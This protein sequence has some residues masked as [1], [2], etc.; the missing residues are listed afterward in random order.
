MYK[1]TT[2]PISITHSD[3]M[4]KVTG[5]TLV[6]GQ[7]YM[8]TDYIAYTSQ[9]GTT[10]NSLSSTKFNLIVTA[11]STSKL[12]EHA[13]AVAKSDT[14]TTAANY[15]LWE[16]WYDIKNDTNKYTWIVDNGGNDSPKGVIYRM[17]DEYGNDLPY[18]FKN[19]KFYLY[20]ASGFT[21]TTNSTYLQN[22]GITYNNTYKFY[23]AMTTKY[24]A[25][26][27]FIPATETTFV[28]SQ[29]NSSAITSWTRSSKSK[30]CYTFDYSSADASLSG[31]VKNVRMKPTYDVSGVKQQLN[32]NVF[33][34]CSSCY[35]VELSQ[36]CWENVFYGNVYNITLGAS[37]FRNRLFECNTVNLGDKCSNN[38]IGTL[39]ILTY[40]ETTGEYTSHNTQIYTSNITIGHGCTGNLFASSTNNIVIGD[41][42]TDN[43]IANSSFSRMGNDCGQN[44]LCSIW[45]VDG[46]YQ[47]GQRFT[48]G[49][50]VL[51]FFTTNTGGIESTP[52]GHIT[53]GNNVRNIALSDTSK[54]KVSGD[55]TAV[56]F[57]SE[58][59]MINIASGTNAYKS[60]YIKELTVKTY[61]NTDP[62][63][64]QIYISSNNTTL[65]IV[66]GSKFRIYDGNKIQCGSVYSYGDGFYDYS[67]ERL[68]DFS[69]D[70]DIDFDEL[71]NIPKKYFKWKSNDT[72]IHI[73]TSAQ[74]IQKIY[75]EIVKS[76]DD[77]ILTVAYDKL[78]IV[79]LAAIDKLYEE[80][81][82][83]KQRLDILENNK[84]KNE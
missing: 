29:Y 20:T 16:I 41:M 38:T 54:R 3:L 53:V 34:V 49:D 22:A 55:N 65:N 7:Q 83:L 37:C 5:K 13:K 48:I 71:K 43:Y 18:D 58:T 44:C 72:N 21:V 66:D 12:S 46:E 81:R 1:C 39:Y 9:T 76:D 32:Y 70:I 82:Q 74:E 8:I 63:V 31:R 30:E 4:T 42:C 77:G 73:G 10:Y 47:T 62:Y 69:G 67:D 60:S 64:N 52:F 19:I 33:L 28:I 56:R 24:N 57:Q 36:Y 11:V 45:D 15:H 84:L 59:K 27:Y 6:P 26:F 2:Q 23:G 25:S 61:G 51:R 40:N 14:D 78:S 68:K 50:H 79:A 35:N 75:P 80:N 17:I